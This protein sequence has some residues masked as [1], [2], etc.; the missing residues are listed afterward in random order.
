M[1]I[2]LSLFLLW[3][4]QAKPVADAATFRVDRVYVFAKYDSSFAL[5]LANELI[6]PDRDVTQAEVDCLL[7]DLKASGLFDR[8]EAKWTNSGGNV[9]TLTLHCR[10]TPGREHFVVSKISLVGLR[11]V[12]PKAFSKSLAD[13]G[14]KP[15]VR[16]LQFTYDTLNELVDDSIRRAVSPELVSEYG[17]SAWISFKVNGL[18]H[19]EIKVF[20]SKPKC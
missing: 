1:P 2:I 15:G 6:P 10:P 11:E 12:D 8:I 14:L 3:T 17:G 16:L 19:V 9:R 13:K 4:G 5:A 18:R 7:S 20:S